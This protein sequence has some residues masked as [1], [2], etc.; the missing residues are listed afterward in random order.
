MAEARWKELLWLSFSGERVITGALDLTALA[1]L[2][3]FQRL[4]TET[5]RAGF[6][7]TNPSRQRVPKGFEDAARLF[8]RR[9]DAG[10]AIAPLELSLTP[11]QVLLPFDD[12]PIEDYIENAVNLALRTFEALERDERLPFEITRETLASYGDFAVS[13]PENDAVTVSLPNRENARVVTR[14]TAKKIDARKIPL[15][16]DYFDLVGEVLEVD[17]KKGRF[18][19]WLDART[20]LPLPFSTDQEDVVTGALK[21]HASVR[22]RAKGRGLFNGDGELVQVLELAG[23][24]DA[25]VSKPREPESKPGLL[26]DLL[27]ISESIPGPE[28]SRLPRDLSE[29]IDHYLYGNRKR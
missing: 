1:S 8:L 25:G 16:E 9:V 5:A 17:L 14:E 4:L 19:L 22:L 23:I 18:Q 26:G 12:V 21:D 29:N 11:G 6:L 7:A 20:R 28:R 10:S 13:I 27:A 2:A 15:Y 3:S 24:G